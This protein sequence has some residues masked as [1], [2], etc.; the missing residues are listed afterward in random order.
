MV[1]PK[2]VSG[3]RDDP[4]DI[5]LLMVMRVKKHHHVPPADLPDSVGQ[6]IDE[7]PVLSS[8][9]GSMLVPSTRTG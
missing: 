9:T 2:I 4:L 5:A 7:E 6:L 3:E 1:D 8:S